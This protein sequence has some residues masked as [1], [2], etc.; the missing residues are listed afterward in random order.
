MLYSTDLSACLVSVAFDVMSYLGKYNGII[1][2]VNTIPLKVLCK[3]KSLC[4]LFGNLQK[5]TPLEVQR[6]VLR[7]LKV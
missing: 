4:A 1:I 2:L 3:W 5:L 7:V 6:I